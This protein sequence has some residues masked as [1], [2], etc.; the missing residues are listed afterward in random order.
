VP[1][2]FSSI[3]ITDD[4]TSVQQAILHAARTGRA[5]PAPGGEHVIVWTD[6]GSG[7]SLAVTGTSSGRIACVK[8]YVAHSGRSAAVRLDGLSVDPGCAYCSVLVVEVLSPGT[9]EMSYPLAV[10]L[11]DA[12]AVMADIRPGHLVELRVSGIAERIDLFVDESAYR[13]SGTPFATRS[14][15]PSGLFTPA[16]A[17]RDDDRPP[18]AEAL[19]SG[20]VLDASLRRNGASGGEFWHLLVE[21]LDLQIDLAVDTRLV[22]GSPVPGWICSATAWLVGAVDSTGPSSTVPREAP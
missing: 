7:A 19:V 14:L 11:P 1:S 8:P 15:V 3:G 13:A 10:E 12:A 21:S 20:E 5:E 4:P 6:P 16:T 22:D 2:H 17:A 18:R 9:Q